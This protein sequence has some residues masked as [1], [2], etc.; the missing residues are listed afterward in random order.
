MSVQPLAVQQS[1][2]LVQSVE[3]ST[4]IYVEALYSRWLGVSVG[5]RVG[6]EPRIE[7]ARIHRAPRDCQRGPPSSLRAYRMYWESKREIGW[8]GCGSLCLSRFSPSPSLS[9]F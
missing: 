4:L 8:D 1:C 5:R 2:M 9:P 6:F 3:E 7:E